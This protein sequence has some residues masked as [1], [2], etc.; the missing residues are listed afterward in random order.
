MVLGR[1]VPPMLQQAG[2][3]DKL[4]IP[5]RLE[6]LRAFRLPHTEVSGQEDSVSCGPFCLAF[7]ECIVGNLSIPDTIDQSYI[8][9]FRKLAS[10]KIFAHGQ[11]IK[12]KK[13]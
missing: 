1:L 5:P 6:M 2:Y 13:R 3:F 8:P 7:L 11:E 4:H 12:T 10:L 9:E